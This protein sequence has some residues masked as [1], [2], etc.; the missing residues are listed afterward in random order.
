MTWLAMALLALAVRLSSSGHTSNCVHRDIVSLTAQG[1]NEGGY[2][3]IFPLKNWGT[4]ERKK[5]LRE[6][7]PEPSGSA[8]VSVGQRRGLW[9]KWARWAGVAAL[10]VGR[11]S[12]GSRN[13]D[14]LAAKFGNVSSTFANVVGSNDVL[15]S[16]HD[17][18]GILGPTQPVVRS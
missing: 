2:T 5:D 13:S 4:R 9:E 7:R 6:P 10:R 16:L 3:V 8:C 18:V 17:L 11:P 15:I 12:A 1:E 14:H